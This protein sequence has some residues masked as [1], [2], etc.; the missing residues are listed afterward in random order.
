VALDENDY[1][2]KCYLKK[3]SNIT[4]LDKLFQ[5]DTKLD[6]MLENSIS[7]WFQSDRNQF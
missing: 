7:I 5:T 3:V 6:D 1:V 2:R 4:V